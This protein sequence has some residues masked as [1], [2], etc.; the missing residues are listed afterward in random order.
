M[1]LL[2]DLSQGVM[3]A[4]L[5]LGLFMASHDSVRADVEDPVGVACPDDVATCTQMMSAKCTA[6]QLNKACG[7]TAGCK[8]Q[9]K[10]ARGGVDICKCS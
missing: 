6:T 1:R 4:V 5:C 3:A 9:N 10:K 2:F 8:C 7:K